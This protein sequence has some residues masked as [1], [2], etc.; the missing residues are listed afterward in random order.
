[1]LYF[2]KPYFLKDMPLRIIL[3]TATSSEAD[4]LKT[5]PGMKIISEGFFFKGNEIIPLITGVGSVATSWAMTKI[6]SS[7]VK[8]D[9]AINIGIAGSFRDDI[10]V[11]EVVVPLSDCFADAGIETGSG[12]LTLAE[13]GLVDPDA[14][15]FKSG[16]IFS[17]NRFVSKAGRL[18][19]PVNAITVNTSTGTQNNIKLISE[20]YHPDIETMEGAAFF[21]VCSRENIPFLAIRA[22]SNKVEPRNREKWN[23]PLAIN[24]LSEKFGE[25]LL[26]FD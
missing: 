11:G 10:P 7:G 15:P 8:A 9:L 19:R 13:A 20:R 18:L 25:L 1:M 4:T 26:S 6:F 2:I 17:D 23:I 24:N 12:F 3:V 14:F 5:I 21:Y 16:R 22:V